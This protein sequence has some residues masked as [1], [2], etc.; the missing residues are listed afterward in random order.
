VVSAVILMAL[1]TAPAVVR[2]E[3]IAL[4]AN[5]MMQEPRYELVFSGTVVAITRTADAA[6]RATFTVDRVWKGSMSK[7]FDLYVWSLFSEAPQ[8]EMG[9]RYVAVPERLIDPRVSGR[10]WIGVF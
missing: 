7:T 8:F 2:A 3:C 10:R 1:A 9:Q 6:Y 4:S 5:T